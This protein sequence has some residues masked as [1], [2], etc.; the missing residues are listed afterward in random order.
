MKVT[1]YE[2][3]YHEDHGAILKHK[4]GKRRQ[5]HCPFSLFLSFYF[6][7]PF[8][9]LFFL[10]P[11]FSFWPFSFFSFFSFCKVRSLIPTCGGII[12]FIILSSLG[13][14]SNNEDH[15]TFMDLHSKLEQHMTLY[16]CLRRC[17]GICNESRATCMKIMKVALTHLWS[18][19]LAVIPG[20]SEEIVA[21]TIYR[22]PGSNKAMNLQWQAEIIV[23]VSDFDGEDLHAT[24]RKSICWVGSGCTANGTKRSC[25]EEAKLIN[26][27]KLFKLSDRYSGYQYQLVA[28]KEVQHYLIQRP[29]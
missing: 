17:T 19:G 29:G 13:Q 22:V 6:F 20:A 14:C 24:L 25:M 10:W 28:R 5:Q 9:F 26:I 27:E 11:F 4:C 18:E 2:T 21:F 8:F 1:T 12:V 3:L 23:Q 7:F 15:H 16:E